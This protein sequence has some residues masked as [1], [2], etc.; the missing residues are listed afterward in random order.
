MDDSK[1]YMIPTSRKEMNA[2]GWA[3]ADVILFSGD[4]YVD[5]PSFGIAVLARM[6]QAYGYKVALVPQPNWQDDLRDFKKLGQPRLFFGVS[7]GNMD[8]MVNHYTANRRLR[9]DDAY[10]PGG[11]AGQRPDYAAMVYARILKEMFPEVPLVIGGIEASMRRFTHY[12]YWQDA[13]R[14]GILPESKADILIFGMAEYPLLSVAEAIKRGA[15]RAQLMKIP[16]TQFLCQNLPETTPMLFLNSHEDCLQDKKAFAEN[17]VQFE[18]NAN[19]VQELPVAQKTGGY[20]LYTNPSMPALSCAKL[21]KIY[22]L[23]YTRK[24]HP[25]YK[26][27]PEIPAYQ[28]IRH[29]VNSHRG[30][31]GGCAFCTIVAQQGKWIQSRSLKSIRREVNKISQMD[32]FRGHITDLGGP[33]A[34]MYRMKPVDMN[35]CR[36]CSRLSCIYPSI[37]KNL[38]IDHKPLID[39]YQQLMKNPEVKQLTIGSGIRHDLIFGAK[40]KYREPALQYFRLLV[41]KHVS[42][43]LKVAPEHTEKHVL[44]RMRKPGFELFEQMKVAFDQINRETGKNQQLIPYF[45]SGYPGCTISDMINLVK[46]SRRLKLIMDQMQDFTP[47]PMT[48]ATVIYYTGTDP[49]TGEKVHVPGA[50]EKRKQRIHSL[51]RG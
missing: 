2:L 31:F 27:K 36:N 47:T 1:L 4:A 44:K 38:N 32:D 41:S 37:C 50:N 23:P 5:H 51:I 28:M 26:G 43:R 29:S 40:G 20:W 8:S 13:L 33:S 34:N 16:Q 17:F 15:P 18:H 24:P 48:L 7:A 35:V 6:L 45:I 3:Q 12:D 11:R 25:R 14:P 9:S 19:A 49:Y 21:D 10:T 46:R 42:G 22:D 39:V 30:C